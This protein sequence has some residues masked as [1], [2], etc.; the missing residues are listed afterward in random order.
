MRNTETLVIGGGQAGLAMSRCLGE[1][2]VDHVVIERGR[3]GE[4]WRN[5][6]WDSL[7]LLTPNWMSRLP[8]WSYRGDDPDGFMGRRE[9]VAFLDAYAR[10]F[11]APVMEETTVLSAAPAGDGWRV[12]TDRGTWSARN[13][14]VATG[15]CDKPRIPGLAAA[16]DRRIQQ[17]D[18]TRY[19]NPWQLPDGGVLV[20]GASAT[21]VQLAREI[22]RS[23]RPVTLAV[24]SHNRLPRRYRGRDIVG[25][26]DRLGILDRTL[27]DMPN[28]RQARHEPSLQLVGRDGSGADAQGLAATLDLAALAAEGVRLAGHLRSADGRRVGFAGDLLQVVADADDRLA[29]LLDRI[30]HHVASHGLDER[31]PAE[32]R[33]ARLALAG[34]GPAE[35]DLEAAG[36]TSV[37]WATGYRRVYPWLHAPVLDAAGEIRQVRGRTPR[38]GLYVLGMQFMIRRRSSFLDGVGRDAAEIADEIAGVTA[39]SSSLLLALR[40]A[41]LRVAA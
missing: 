17:L 11:A 40:A 27:A 25:W 15:H 18:P 41:P 33:P 36:I 3:V 1:R 37:L 7:R 19:R 24:G 5:Q 14:V 4:R 22:H 20:V 16:L 39:R 29:R 10:S 31:Y 28:P 8:G 13:V 2:G 30:D 9:V 23:G 12:V 32:P 38:A 6:R 34:P 35:L 26:L 21:G